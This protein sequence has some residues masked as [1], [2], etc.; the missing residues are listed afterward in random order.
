MFVWERDDILKLA[1]NLK[2]VLES[3][4][5]G[6]KV[7]HFLECIWGSLSGETLVDCN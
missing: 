4:D 1:F 3:C 7:Y 5:G 2:N 6:V